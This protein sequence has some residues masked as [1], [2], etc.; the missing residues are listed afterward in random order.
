MAPRILPIRVRRVESLDAAAAEFTASEQPV[1]F[2]AM[3]VNDKA[4]IGKSVA[5][6]GEVLDVRRQG[7]QTIVLL[8]VAKTSGCTEK[9]CPVRLVIGAET[10]AKKG[11]KVR[12]FG[13]VA[14]PFTAGGAAVPE[15][16]VEFLVGPAEARAGA[17]AGAP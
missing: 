16:D 4:A 3:G 2:A 14:P 6:T 10:T 5:L 11:D 7:Y 13:R 15:V 17:K 12:A 9:S 8:D 1:D